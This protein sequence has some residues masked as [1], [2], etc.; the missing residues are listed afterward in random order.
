MNTLILMLLGHGWVREPLHSLWQTTITRYKIKLNI[1]KD[2]IK[3]RGQTVKLIK[4]LAR[5]NPYA[6]KDNDA[7]TKY[8]RMKNV[9]MGTP[10][11]RR[12]IVMSPGLRMTTKY[13]KKF[14]KAGHFTT[15]DMRSEIARHE[16]LKSLEE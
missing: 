15:A 11:H 13:I 4:K 6:V 12:P 2:D 16:E 7:G 14:Y 8:G 10:D 5:T 1:E 3:M 9:P